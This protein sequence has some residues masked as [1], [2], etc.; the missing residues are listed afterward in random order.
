MNLAVPGPEPS[1]RAKVSQQEY[2]CLV[3]VSRS[4]LEDMGIDPDGDLEVNR[5]VYDNN[6]DRA[7]M[8]LR[9]YDSS[10]ESADD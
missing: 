3:P 9:F 1:K 8:R 10:D 6:S 5:Y 2:G 7:E 4:Q